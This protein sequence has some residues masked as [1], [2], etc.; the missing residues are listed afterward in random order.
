MCG[1]W[2]ALA[3]GLFATPTV[4]ELGTGLFYGNPGQLWIQIVSIVATALFTAIGTL[5]VLY[6]TKLVT[7]GLRV[8]SEDEV[9]G[10]D[11]AIHGERAFELD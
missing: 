11:N 1:V 2:G 4:N 5:A 10:L 9:V 7:S 3:T 8:D 6:V